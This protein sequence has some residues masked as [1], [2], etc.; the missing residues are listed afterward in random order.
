MLI[1][2][3]IKDAIEKHNIVVPIELKHGPQRAFLVGYKDV[4][5]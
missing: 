5:F 1:E 4:V 3:R 2:S